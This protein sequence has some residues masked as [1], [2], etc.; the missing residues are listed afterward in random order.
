[1]SEPDVDEIIQSHVR[2]RARRTSVGLISLLQM[3]SFVS[4][5]FPHD[6]TI[7]KTRFAPTG[8]LKQSL[9]QNYQTPL[10]PYFSEEDK[11]FFVETF[12]RNGFEAPTGWYKIMTSQLSA[13]DDEREHNILYTDLSVSGS[14]PSLHP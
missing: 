8:A 12:R 7:V 11:R 3:D 6:P 2:A 13:E 10:A 4:I 9:L 1:M 5:M 14:S